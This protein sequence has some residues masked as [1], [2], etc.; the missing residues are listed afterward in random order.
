MLITILTPT[1]ALQNSLDFY[2]KLGF[3]QLSEGPVVF[4]D[5]KALVEIDPDRYARAGIKL[6][7]R[8]WKGD[9]EML[10]MLTAVTRTQEGALLGDMNGVRISLCG[11]EPPPGI[12]IEE[13]SYSALGNFAGLSLET[14]DMD[15]SSAIYEALGF[16]RVGGSPEAGYISLALEDFTVNLMRPLSCPH[17]FFNPSMT[18]F[19]GKNNLAVIQKIR[20]L[21]I[22]ITEEITHF[23]KEGIVDN[24]I[25]RDPGGYGFFVFND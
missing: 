3:R 13:S 17:L 8:N 10:Q 21:G 12:L 23:N 19:N 4:T 7:K 6:Y 18:Y 5:G 9:L 1:N 16:S 11:L 24:V 14:T 20:D 25:I 22:P 15:K 2:S